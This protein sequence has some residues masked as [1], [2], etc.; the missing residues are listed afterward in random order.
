MRGAIFNMLGD[1]EDLSILD[2]FAGSGALTLEAI[3]RGGATVTGIDVDNKAYKVFTKNAVS[4][5]VSDK[6]TIIKA[7]AGK[8]SKQNP[9]ELFDVVLLDPP[10]NDID[11]SMIRSLGLHAKPKGV[12]VVSVPADCPILITTSAFEMLAQ[13]TYGDAQLQIYRKL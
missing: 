1:I 4:L 8:W 3:S 6:V 10:Y 5:G 11:P 7:D 2:G 13:K 9:R 12:V